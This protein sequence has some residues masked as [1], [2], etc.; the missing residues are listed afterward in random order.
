M[1]NDRDTP[2]SLTREKGRADLMPQPRPPAPTSVS[3]QA[4][5]FLATEMNTGDDSPALDDTNAWLRYVER[6]NSIMAGRF[7]NLELPV[8]VV[9]LEIEGVRTYVLRASDVPD[10]DAP[11]YM[12]I[13]GGGL[14][15]G[16]GELC[17][18]MASATAMTNGMGPGHP[19]TG[20]RRHTPIRPPSR[21]T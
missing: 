19:T 20:C 2:N 13:H 6:G 14:L 11:I 7:A 4:Q 9:E 10:D 5:R 3:E 12:D 16:G 8:T 1:I 18:Q 15:F 17:R 21:I